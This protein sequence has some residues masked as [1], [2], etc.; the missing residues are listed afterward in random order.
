MGNLRLFPMAPFSQ[1]IQRSGKTAQFRPLVGSPLGVILYK[2]FIAD[3]LV[4]KTASAPT[5]ESADRAAEE[6]AIGKAA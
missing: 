1:V 5:T 3:G 6:E 4:A 2:F